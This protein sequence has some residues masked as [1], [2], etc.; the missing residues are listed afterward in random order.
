MR[1]AAVVLVA[2]VAGVLA[3]GVGAAAPVRD[4]SGP[5]CRIYVHNITHISTNDCDAARAVV[6]SWLSHD[7]PCNHHGVHAC[8]PLGSW[9]CAMVNHSGGG[10]YLVTVGCHG[11]HDANRHEHVSF[12]YGY[13]G[14]A[15]R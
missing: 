9:R 2:G 15:G 12:H 6:Y 14:G 11:T 10:E 5:Q 13:S 3:A 8:H 4:L 7:S 1:L